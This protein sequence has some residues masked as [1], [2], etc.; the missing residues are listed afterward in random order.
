M[1]VLFVGGGNM[2]QAIMGGLIAQKT[3]PED[4]RVI[5][6]VA[7]IRATI[8]TL[9]VNAAAALTSDGLDADVIVLAVKPQ[10]MREAIAPIAGS[11]TNQLVISIAAGVDTRSLAIWLGTSA[12][13]YQNIVRTMPNT[14]ALIRAG[15]TGLYALPTVSA[16]HRQIAESLLGAVGK[17]VWFSEEAMLDA[18]TAVSGSGPAYVFYFMEALE[19]AALELGF[20][21]DAAR[22]FASQTFAGGTQLAMASNDPPSVLRARVTSKRGTTESAIASF[23]E[24]GLKKAFIAGVK[25]ACA[26]SHELGRELG[27]TDTTPR[28]TARSSS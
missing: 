21:P 25:A 19:E 4:F 15:I 18:V 22:L 1:K 23:D 8:S 12:Q 26:R 20:A 24:H 10:M 7:E 16:G 5:D 6:P 27:A 14:P 28:D 2:A 17:T 11:L 3:P 9:G 13:P